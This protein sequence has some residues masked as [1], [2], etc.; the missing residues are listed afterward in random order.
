V[1]AG[2]LA[3]C[4]ASTIP[5]VHSEAERLEQG[6][7]ALES[8]DYNVALELLKSYVAN[9]AGG[10]DVDQAIELLGQSYLRIHEW[11]EAQ[12]QFDRLLRDYPESDSAAAASYHLGEAL[13]GQSRGP[14]FDQEYTQKALEQWEGYLRA[15]PG[16]WLNPEGEK[17]AQRARERLADKLVDAGTLYLKLRRSG[18]A[19][20]YFQRALDEYPTTATAAWAQLGLALADAQDG[21]RDQAAGALRELQSRFG[22]QPV[23]RRA[24]RE[25]AELERHAAKH[26]PT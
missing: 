17:W 23:A 15:Y 16:H 11:A 20:V 8:H 13:W 19:R 12:S 3:G 9:N 24:A 10:A 5:A 21:K 6:R 4:G 18:P 1:L 2:L 25:L 14:E 26:K 22:S 7:R